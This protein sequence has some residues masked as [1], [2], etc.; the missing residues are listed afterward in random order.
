M[1]EMGFM[2]SVRD[3][4][5]LTIPNADFSE[6]LLFKDDLDS[7]DSEVVMRLRMSSTPRIRFVHAQEFVDD[8]GREEMVDLASDDENIRRL[9]VTVVSRTRN[10]ANSLG[11]LQVVIHPG[12]IRG[13]EVDKR[14]LMGNLRRSLA[15]LGPTNLLLE[16]MPWYYWLRKN[17]RM[18][19]NLCVSVE[20]MK[21]VGH[22]VEGVVL[23]ASH[24]YLSKEDGDPTYC[25]RFLEALGPKVM[26]IHVSDARAPDREGLQI[27]SG[28]VD[29]SFLKGV[30]VPVL[31]EVWNGHEKKGTEFVAGIRRLKALESKW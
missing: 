1:L 4:E 18:V 6:L 31:V 5:S 20:D 14:R 12:G 29:M 16:N 25:R 10:L 11:G 24:G 17:E 21:R 19:A 27:G 30:T 13:Q 28:Q 9:S 22:L 15:E 3:F 23:D 7:M 8:D 2:V 26:H